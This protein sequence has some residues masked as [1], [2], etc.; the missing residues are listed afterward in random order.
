MVGNTVLDTLPN[1]ILTYYS[2]RVIITLHRRD[3]LDTIQQWFTQLNNIARDH[4]ELEFV[5]PVHPNT[6]IIKHCNL[7]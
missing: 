4:P 5:L 2:N 7:L 1:D 6:S 3:N